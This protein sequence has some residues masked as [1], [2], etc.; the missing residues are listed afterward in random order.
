VARDSKDIL[1]KL[2][3]NALTE[4]NF[5]ILVD[6]LIFR[7]GLAKG[8]TEVIAKEF[9]DVRVKMLQTFNELGTVANLDSKHHHGSSHRTRQF[10]NVFRRKLRVDD[11][12]FSGASFCQDGI[13]M[14]TQA[15]GT[16]HELCELLRKE[17]DH[18]IDAVSAL[19]NWWSESLRFLIK[20]K[21]DEGRL[22]G[23]GSQATIFLS[24]LEDYWYTVE[25]RFK[26]YRETVNFF[27]DVAGIEK[28]T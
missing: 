7:A 27:D 15:K 1:C 20:L 22:I 5:R 17:L 8:D 12:A 28:S 21:D 23:K 13:D 2:K 6:D 24:R 11:I 14:D 19:V 26:E 25:K 9:K 4:K 10:K 16:V 3:R 18:A